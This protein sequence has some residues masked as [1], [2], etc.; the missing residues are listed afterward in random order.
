MVFFGKIAE[1]VIFFCDEKDIA[2]SFVYWAAN[3]FGKKT[4][5]EQSAR[6]E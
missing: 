6:D 2:G 3:C 5:I 4:S 1:K